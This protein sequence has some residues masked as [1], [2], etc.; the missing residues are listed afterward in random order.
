MWADAGWAVKPKGSDRIYKIWRSQCVMKG[1]KMNKELLK[2]MI[3]CISP[4]GREEMLQ[5]CIY[6]HYKQDFDTFMVEEQGTLTGI[7]N[8]D[9][10]FKIQLA[11]H[12]DEISLV[13]TGYNEDGSLQVADNGHVYP[14]LY[15]GAKV[16]ILTDSGIVKGVV[17]HTQ[18][19]HKKEE[20]RCRDLFVDIGCESA[21]EAEQTVP[22]GSYLVHDTDMIELQKD[23]LAGRA[24][25]DRIGV[26]IVFEAA[27]KAAQMGTSHGIYAT[28]T[29]GEENTG[30]GAYASASRIKPNICVAV[31][32]T[33]A[34]DYRDADADGNVKLGK[35]GVICRGSIPN[36]KL[37]SLLE[38]CAKELDLPVQFEVF[39]G[40]TYTDAD[41][42]L[43]TNESVPQVLFSVPLRY[44]H[45]PVEVLSM[46][47]VDSMVE[48][49]A[50][51]LTK[52]S[53]EDSLL[54]YRL[55]ED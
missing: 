23:K 25:D 7:V 31:D 49:L 47:D 41:T 11:G 26:Y 24:F 14:K 54:P 2:E 28:A 6:R 29:T 53:P 44:M 33:Y 35:G 46:K 5:K 21:E 10:D 39:S 55:D 17:G 30:R 32:V 51:F 40:R 52:I 34:A 19:L 3:T 50:F 12:A 20:V 4:S 18:A 15:V 1:V 16:Q 22:K 27:K 37:N 36:R 42:M 48:I 8:P 13:V 45:S 9:A 43:K 38:A